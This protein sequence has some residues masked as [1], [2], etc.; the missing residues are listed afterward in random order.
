IT[1]FNTSS[2]SIHVAWGPVPEGHHNGII[3]G[4]KVFFKIN[5]ST[6]SINNVIISNASQLNIEISGLGKYELYSIWILAFTVKGNGNVSTP[7]YC[8]TDE[9][10]PQ[11]AP[12]NI[13]ATAE[14]ST[15]IRVRWDPIDPSRTRGIHRGYRVCY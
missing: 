10:E 8:R 11:D 1:T 14:S 2:T 5:A 13:T 12:A 4:Y 15:S 7:V 6:E 3:L 9:D